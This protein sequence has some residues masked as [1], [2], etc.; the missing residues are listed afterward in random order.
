MSQSNHVTVSDGASLEVVIEQ[1]RAAGR[2]A[3]DTEFMRE[4]TYR[5]RL[6]LVQIAV[7]EP[8]YVI[9]PLKEVDL[10]P[11]ARLLAEDSLEVVV[12]AG[13][14]D[15]E[16]FNERFGVT[17]AHAF[18][19]QIAAGFAG[20]G[21]SLPYGRLI[22]ATTGVR[23]SKSESYTDWCKRP[24]TDAQVSYAAD[25]VRYLLGAADEIKRRLDEQGRLDWALDEMAGLSAESTYSIDPDE[26][27]KRISGRGSLT[28]G[29]LAVLRE[30]ARWR[31]ETAMKRDIP[32]GWVV[33]DQSLIEMARRSPKTAGALKSIRGFPAKEADRSGNAIVA[34]IERGRN[35]GPIETPPAPPRSAQIRTRATV[36]LADAL[37]R[38]RC[39]KAGVASELVA[40][41][42][43]L[44]TLLTSVFAHNE[45][46]KDH[47]LW[48]GWRRDLVG[49]DLVALA[50]GQV[51]LRSIE[52]PPYIEE[53]G[54]R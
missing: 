35:A 16:I 8:S 25:D 27:Y 3:L 4:K 2:I 39:E 53:V 32:R 18:D 49:N 6:C 9:D 31:E 41:R 22:Q 24:L 20:L 50:R 7:S 10:A 26:H 28:G 43:D 40:T 13:R 44:E 36:G 5:A 51:A 21:A 46:P 33:K 29:Q 11:L 38:A 45:P 42:S 54:L 52:T 37:I 12:H 15:F 17:P 1:G 47:R 23:L 48:T 30:L 19:V 34:A 14:Q